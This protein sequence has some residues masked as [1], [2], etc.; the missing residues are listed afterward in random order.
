M[1]S[2]GRLAGT[3]LAFLLLAGCLGS[4][5]A[6]SPEEPLSEGARI[7]EHLAARPPRSLQAVEPFEAVARDG[8][9]LRGHVYVPD[10]GGAVP[11]VLEFSP[12]FNAGAGEG[13]TSADH[14]TLVDGRPTMR[15]RHQ[16][17]LDAGYAVALVNLRGS[18][19]SG[20][21]FQWGTPLD[22]QDAHDVVEALAAL[23][24]SD[25]QVAMMGL[26]YPGWTQFWA[27]AAA[28]PSLKA[29]IPVSGVIDL[30]SLL[31]RNGAPIL[32]ASG[33]TT[34]WEAEY[35]VAEAPYLPQE[36][37][38]G[39]TLQH[40]DCGNVYAEHVAEGLALQTLG[41]RN[42]FWEERDLRPRLAASR[43]PILFT[44]G[45][46]DGEG[47]VL[48][49][50]GLWDLLPH[51]QKRMLIGQWGH[52]F[53]VDPP[54]EFW[55]MSVAWLDTH[56]R[57][58]PPLLEPGVVEYQDR[59]LAWHRADRWP[60]TSTPVDL[61]LS[62]AALMA[63]GTAAASTQTFGSVYR[64]PTIAECPPPLAQAMYVS[65]PLESEV[66]LAGNLH[67]NLTVTSTGPD[68][69]FAAFLYATPGDGSCPDGQA[70]EVARALTDLRHAW[71]GAEG[72]PF[73][74]GTPSRLDLR[75]HPFAAA[76]HAGERLVLVLGGEAMELQPDHSRPVLSVSTGPGVAGALRLP[77][78]EGTLTFG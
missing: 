72:E 42:T 24:H 43:V 67:L 71:P 14:A 55:N 65:P 27:L 39:P 58:A 7:S 21:C 48:Q 36:G 63:Q 35:S 28:P 34:L 20:G 38:G 29:V 46:T 47:H 75:S 9:P 60:P 23:P 59:E 57:G 1:R 19:V 32:G 64:D 16:H 78:V 12:Y 5:P 37:G 30:H 62:D 40:T 66:L 69:N 41:D 61:L 52:G 49:F 22:V 45:M 8:V 18:G 77:V 50:E 13:T 26:S 10:S 17:F 11:T 74:V 31:T 53:P 2:F 25:G 56:L 76:V 51:G 6:G 73:P 70:R 33:V 4:T 3:C 54:T 68:G 15:G 44:N